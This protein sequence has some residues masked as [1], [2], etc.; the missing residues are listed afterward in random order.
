MTSNARRRHLNF[1]GDVLNVRGS[2][3]LEAEHNFFTRRLVQRMEMR[4]F[5][6]CAHLSLNSQTLYEY[7]FTIYT[8]YTFRL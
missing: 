3:P 6:M 1:M 4:C 2:Q 7:K 8:I 5:H